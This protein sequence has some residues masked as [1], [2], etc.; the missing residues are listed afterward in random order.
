[1]PAGDD[2]EEAATRWRTFV[3]DKDA[4]FDET[5]VLNAPTSPPS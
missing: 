3:S 1:V 2:F 5:I 4:S